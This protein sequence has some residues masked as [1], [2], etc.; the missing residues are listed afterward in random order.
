MICQERG[1]ENLWNYWICT[2]SKRK[3]RECDGNRK[4]GRKVVWGDGWGG[5]ENRLEGENERRGDLGPRLGPKDSLEVI[6][7][8]QNGE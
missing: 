5:N 2:A 1:A 8:R 3:R 6:I 4:N 7:S